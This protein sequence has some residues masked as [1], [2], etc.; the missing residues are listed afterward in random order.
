MVS[1]NPILKF[2]IQFELK[3]G[4]ADISFDPAELHH[5]SMYQ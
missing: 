4:V 1:E 3:P 5:L 2:Q